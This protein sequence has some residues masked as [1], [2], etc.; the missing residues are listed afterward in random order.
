MEALKSLNQKRVAKPVSLIDNP[1][2]YDQACLMAAAIAFLTVRQQD[3]IGL[4]FARRG[5]HR[6][7]DVRGGYE[8]LSQV[9]RAMERVRVRDEARLAETLHHYTQR[10][11][12]RSLLIVFSATV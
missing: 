2:K 1:S 8:Q 3:R 10:L 5:L 11:P 7:H 6:E 12:R 9:L 4:A